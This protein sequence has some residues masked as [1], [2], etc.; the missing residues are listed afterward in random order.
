[1]DEQ[2]KTNLEELAN[3]LHIKPKDENLYFLALTHPSYNA[4]A[5][6]KHHDYERLEYI[7]DA[8][9]GFVVAELIFNIHPEM[10]PGQMSKLRS[11]RVKSKSLANYGR[12]I[13]L[14][15]YIRTGHSISPEKINESDKIL[16]DV[17]EAI[18]GAIYLDLGISKA[19]SVIKS[20]FFNDLKHFNIDDLTDYKS[21]LQ[22]EMQ[23]EHRD[24]VTYKVIKEE[25]PSH[26]KT[27]T[28]AVYFNDLVLA[29]GK[30]KSKKEAEENAA[31]EALKKGVK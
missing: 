8:V 26:D 9:L 4:D 10:D 11:Y 29:T 17:F 2:L 31:K 22:E 23:A 24:S 1:M 16:E 7:G 21:R 5:N 28:V 19:T 14:A 3:R 6:T 30:G 18:I 27:F 15:K 13:D 20:L 25:G 12:K